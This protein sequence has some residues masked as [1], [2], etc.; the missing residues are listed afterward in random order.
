MTHAWCSVHGTQQV[1]K[2]HKLSSSLFS[3]RCFLAPYLEWEN[4]REN[5]LR[6]C[7]A[8]LV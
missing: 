6:T 4:T 3:C 8:R 2:E 7:V 5:P 1:P